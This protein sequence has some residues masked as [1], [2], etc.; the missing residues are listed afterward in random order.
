M[1]A[2]FKWL[3]TSGAKAWQKSIGYSP[4]MKLRLRPFRAPLPTTPSMRWCAHWQEHRRHNVA[5][6]TF[7]T[8]RCR[9]KYALLFPGSLCPQ[10]QLSN[11]TSPVANVCVANS[12]T[13]SSGQLAHPGGCSKEQNL[14][15]LTW[16][17]HNCTEKMMKPAPSIEVVPAWRLTSCCTV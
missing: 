5:R 11:R 7:A 9:F 2:H 10:A 16:C 17:S 15:A 13:I 6:G 14:P 4:A 8:K 3:S 12:F 1:H